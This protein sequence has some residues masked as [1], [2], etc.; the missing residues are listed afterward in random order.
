MKKRKNISLII[1]CGIIII[2]IFSLII[3]VIMLTPK[4]DKINSESIA[5]SYFITNSS[6]IEYQ[7]N[8]DCSA[9]ATA[10]V[11]RCLGEDV[12]GKELYP[13]M[14]RFFGMMTA[15]CIERA[16]EKQGYLAKAYSGN[17]STLKQRLNGGIP[18]ICLVRNGK[19]T[20]YVAVV[21][22]DAEYIYLVDSMKENENVT[23]SNLYNRKVAT[24]EFQKLW[25]NNFYFAN[26]IYI[27]IEP[28]KP[29]DLAMLNA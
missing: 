13:K 29:I 2:A 15:Q 6:D 28:S 21:G 12:H 1:F 24:K 11:L 26:K 16:V 19:D 17:I 20:H 23:N 7:E 14:K 18:I 10:Y 9:Y 4:A 22:Y 5:E 3:G 8:N 27:L 25:K